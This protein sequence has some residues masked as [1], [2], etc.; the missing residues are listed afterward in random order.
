[1]ADRS[2]KERKLIALMLNDL[3]SSMGRDDLSQAEQEAHALPDDELD[4]ALASRLDLPYPTDEEAMDAALLHVAEPETNSGS[5]GNLTAA[6]DM[7]HEP[8]PG[9]HRDQE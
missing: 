2:T 4:R 1:M 9:E 6:P 5:P 7:S 8:G 3:A